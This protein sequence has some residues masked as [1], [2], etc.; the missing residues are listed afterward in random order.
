VELL[1]QLSIAVDFCKLLYAVNEELKFL[2]NLAQYLNILIVDWLM[3][4]VIEAESTCN[5]EHEALVE[6]ACDVKEHLVVVLE[7]QAVIFYVVYHSCLL[8]IEEFPHFEHILEVIT[9]NLVE[10]TLLEAELFLVLLF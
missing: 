2:E 6:L 3:Q 1:S 10:V 5:D 7:L 9:R 4:E 8:L